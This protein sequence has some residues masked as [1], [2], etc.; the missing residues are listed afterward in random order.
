MPARE[1]ISIRFGD[2]NQVMRTEPI[3]IGDDHILDVELSEQFKICAVTI[4]NS[5]EVLRSTPAMGTAGAYHLVHDA[6]K[7]VLCIEFRRE[8]ASRVPSLRLETIEIDGEPMLDLLF[9][10][11]DDLEGILIRKYS[12]RR[13]GELATE[14]H[15]RR[16]WTTRSR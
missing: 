16:W 14:Q 10:S 9:D 2:P 8:V 6:N 13:A 1:D 11:E 15:R 4:V 12:E 7:D 5:Y 3:S